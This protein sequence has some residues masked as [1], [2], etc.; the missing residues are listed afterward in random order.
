[1]LWTILLNIFLLIHFSLAL[2]EKEKADVKD[3]HQLFPSN[4]LLTLEEA[5]KQDKFDRNGFR[6]WIRKYAFSEDHNYNTQRVLAE[7][8]GWAFVYTVRFIFLNKA[9]QQWEIGT[10]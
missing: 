1:M 7:T 9:K 3:A 4:T 6:K 10:G 5:A 8:D 2:S